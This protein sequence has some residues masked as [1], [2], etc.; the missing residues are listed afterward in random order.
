M[1]RSRILGYIL[2]SRLRVG[3]AAAIS[4][5]VLG[6]IEFL[7]HELL[8][9]LNVSPLADA[10]LDALLLGLSSGFTVWLLLSGHRERRARVRQDLLRIAELNHVIRNAL[11]VI[12]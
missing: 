5:V 10:T 9:Y 8:R 1:L 7:V 4:V 12:S 11:Q 2:T 3:S 6:A